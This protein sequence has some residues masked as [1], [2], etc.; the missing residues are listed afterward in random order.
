MKIIISLF[1]GTKFAIPAN[2][3]NLAHYKNSYYG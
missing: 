3:I 1:Y 2:Y